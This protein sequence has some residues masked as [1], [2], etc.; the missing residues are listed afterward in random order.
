MDL[1]KTQTVIITDA[2][3]DDVFPEIR[4]ARRHDDCSTPTECICDAIHAA[5]IRG[6]LATTSAELEAVEDEDDDGT[7]WPHNLPEGRGYSV[8]YDVED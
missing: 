3:L 8:N 2:K 1:R 7:C 5:E 6:E 4:L